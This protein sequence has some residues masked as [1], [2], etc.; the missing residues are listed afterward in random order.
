MQIK[1]ENYYGA[2]LI[3]LILVTGTCMLLSIYNTYCNNCIS[4]NINI[5]NIIKPAKIREYMKPVFGEEECNGILTSE[6]CIINN[7]LNEVKEKTTGLFTDTRYY[8]NKRADTVINK[9]ID[10]I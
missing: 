2:I 3:C 7:P 1:I 4:Q 10:N 8:N 9:S 6:G 5:G